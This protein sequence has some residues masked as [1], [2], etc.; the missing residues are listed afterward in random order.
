MSYEKVQN[1]CN[2]FLNLWGEIQKK[3]VGILCFIK[4]V[5]IYHKGNP[6]PS[7]VGFCHPEMG[8]MSEYGHITTTCFC[9]M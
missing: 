5:K 9:L 4:D 6:V 2:S 1:S 8:M 7:G 3:C